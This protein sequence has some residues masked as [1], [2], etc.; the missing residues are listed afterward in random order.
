MFSNEHLKVLLEKYVDEA[1]DEMK[2][3]IRS[4][5]LVMTG[6]MLNSFRVAATEE[7]NGYIA[8]K[9][10]MI[11]YVRIKDLRSMHYERTP[12]LDAMEYF[13]EANSLHSFN[14]VPGYEDGKWP[15]SDE[16][17]TRR[18][19]WALKM[20]FRRKPNRSRGYRGIYSSSI[21]KA[22]N[23]LKS[24]AAQ[25]GARFAIQYVKNILTQ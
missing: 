15:S 4:Q 23:G 14:Y 21:S 2:R 9:I 17:A 16:I 11:D 24:Q 10:S 18:I 25:A 5:D 19:A 6:E 8:K 20:S 22:M 13:L 1:V 7:G 12:P 3:R